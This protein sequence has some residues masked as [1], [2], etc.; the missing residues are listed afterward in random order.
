M[1]G[2][3][4]AAS[5]MRSAEVPGQ[6]N[7]AELPAGVRRKEVAVTPAGVAPRRDTRGAAQ[8]ELVAHELAVVLPEGTGR[9]AVSG[10]ARMATRGPL[11]DVAIQLT[12]A[13]PVGRGGRC[14]RMKMVA[15]QEVPF[16]FHTAG[17]R[18]PFRLRGQPGARPAGEGVRLVITDVADRLSPVE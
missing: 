1:A 17:G 10:I 2:T 18:L 14:G 5:A 6:A 15:L 9:R 16:L 7:S 12:E 11:P 4:F 8:D 3:E 13:P